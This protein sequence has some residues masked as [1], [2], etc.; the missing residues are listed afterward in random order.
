MVRRRVQGDQEWLPTI[1]RE[2]LKIADDVMMVELADARIYVIEQ[3]RWPEAQDSRLSSRL[4][5]CCVESAKHNLR[6]KKRGNDVIQ[7]AHH[8]LQSLTHD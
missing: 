7:M 4:A 1:W 6:P 2:Q 5:E 8:Y 3:G